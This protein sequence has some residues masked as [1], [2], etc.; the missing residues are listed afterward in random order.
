VINILPFGVDPHSFEPTPKLMIALD[1]SAV[2]FYSGAGLEPWT[3]NFHFP[4]KAVN[5]S[6]YV[7]LRK[8]EKG[9]HEAHHHE[10][11]ENAFDPHYWLDFTNMQKA[12]RVITQELIRISPHNK[13]LY[14]KNEKQYLQML[15]KLDKAYQNNLKECKKEKVVISHNALGYLGK[16]YH[17]TVESLTGLSPEADPSAKDVNRILDDIQKEGIQTVFFENFEN[18]KLIKSIAHDAHVKFELFEPLGNITA[19]EA[20]AGVTYED[21]MKQNLQKLKEALQCR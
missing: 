12:T 11:E 18:E 13:A 14:L 2:V 8:L 21:I 19:D 16:R 20:K 15:E 4:H 1:K 9:E 7:E 17:F 6:K 10:H 3:Q 5:I